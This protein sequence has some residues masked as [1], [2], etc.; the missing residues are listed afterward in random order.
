MKQTFTRLPFFYRLLPS[1]WCLLALLSWGCPAAFA[2]DRVPDACLPGRHYPHGAATGTSAAPL[3]SPTAIAYTWSATGTSASWSAPGS[4]TPARSN[5]DPSDVLQFTNNGAA[6]MVVIDF[7]ASQTIAGLFIGSGSTLTF[8]TDVTRNLTVTDGSAG[9][10][11]SLSNNATLTLYNSST[12]SNDTGLTLQL[13]SGATA[14]VGGQLIFDS[15][16]NSQRTTSHT[17]QGNG[18]N[19][20]EFASGSI[21]TAQTNF[22]GY[23]FGNTTASA[24]SVVF[25]N[26]SR[27]EHNGGNTPF[28]ALSSGTVTSFEPTSY[29]Y[30]TVSAA[31]SLAGRTYGSFEYNPT[32]TSTS[33]AGS[34]PVTFR[35]NLIVTGGTVN[36]MFN[37]GINLQ[38]NLMVNGGTLNLVP[39]TGY[40]FQLNGTTTQ[41]IGGSGILS[42]GSNAVMQVNNAAGVTLARAISLPGTLQL[43]SGL[44]TTSATNALTLAAGATISGG[45]ATSFVNGPL[46]RTVG[47]VSTATAVSFPIGKG[48]DYRP[49]TL[50][51]A[52]QTSTTIYQ[53]EQF[54]QDGGTN[55]IAPLQRVSRFRFYTLTPYDAAAPTTVT[56]PSGF[57]GTLTVSFGASDRVMSPTAASFVVA[58]RADNSQPWVSTGASTGSTTTGTVSEPLGTFAS[59]TLTSANLSGPPFFSD[60]ILASTEAD[61]TVN[62]LPVQLTSFTATRSARGGV[63]LAW[64]TASELRSARF[65]VERSLDGR[66][67]AK[68]TAVA[69]QGSS[70]QAREYATQDV[71]APLDQLYYRLR[72][73]DT[74][75]TASYSPMASV[76]TGGAGELAL[77]PN[78]AHDQLALLT[79]YATAYAVRN[80]LGQVVLAGTTLAGR[81]TS[82]DVSSLAA[83]VYYFELSGGKGRVVR[84]FVK[85]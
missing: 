67:F 38:G 74:D 2:A 68:V 33:S 48:T 39:S 55:F 84:R 71:D 6:S 53:A 11:L 72:L 52:S 51:V 45:S 34:N 20:I 21:F 27:Y 65:E 25:R 9:V 54:N 60:F 14:L 43:T 59:G 66:T 29:Y 41:T 23:A 56:Q 85:E 44:L 32:T 26:G 77:T 63:A 8:S 64:A 17:L 7:G 30:Y 42:F 4:W 13:S 76:A 80:P 78:P 69:A 83:G 28:G 24:N 22:K 50:N 73:V 19:A 37:G 31:A 57:S 36:I 49:L 47:A 3:A 79:E 1:F 70:A 81:P 12:Y 10:D 5:P 18:T 58:K 46:R 62:P 35:G 16:A 61:P 15:A 82:L 75:G 40:T